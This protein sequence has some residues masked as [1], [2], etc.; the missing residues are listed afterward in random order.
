MRPLL[1]TLGY[2]LAVAAVGSAAVTLTIVCLGDRYPRRA[3]F[4]LV[5]LAYALFCLLHHGPL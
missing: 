4:F 5:G 2:L 3:L 1:S